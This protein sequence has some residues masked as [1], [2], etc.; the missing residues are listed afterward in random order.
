MRAADSLEKVCRVHPEWFD[1]Y[2]ERLFAEVAKSNQPS[3]QWHLAQ[4]F[5]EITL[6]PTQKQRA[7]SWLEERLRDK[8]VDWIV[9]ANVMKTLVQY[10]KEGSAPKEK[11]VTLIEGQA[12]H[13][14]ASVRKRAAKYLAELNQ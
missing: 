13:H 11:A 10:V 2:L 4:I 8:N 1:T 12:S 9:A 5:G 6:S 7:T 14:S 3:L